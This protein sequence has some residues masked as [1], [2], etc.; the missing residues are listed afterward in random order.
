MVE[1]TKR[2]NTLGITTE[3]VGEAHT[4]PSSCRRTLNGEA[5]VALIS[6]EDAI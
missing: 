4:N 2:F 5:Q 1:Q 6:P 3:F